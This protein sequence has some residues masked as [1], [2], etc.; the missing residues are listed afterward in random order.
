MRTC[1]YTTAILYFSLVFAGGIGFIVLGQTQMCDIANLNNPVTNSGAIILCSGFI[2]IVG[3][4]CGACNSMD[5]RMQYSI[6]TSFVILFISN[7][8]T[9]T[10]TIKEYGLGVSDRDDCKILSDAA[11]ASSSIQFI[12]I[13]IIIVFIILGGCCCLFESRNPRFKR[14]Q[15]V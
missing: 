2:A 12:H 1:L 3:F 11:L 13:G 8:V 10:K 4:I 14:E 9:A 15:R 5:E 6:T 7:I